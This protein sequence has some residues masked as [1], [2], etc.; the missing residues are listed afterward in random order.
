[1]KKLIA[2]LMVLCLSVSM[3]AGCG[4]K[5]G[6]EKD[7]K[8]KVVKGDMFDMLEAMG[9][10]TSGTVKADF[11]LSF[12]GK[13]TK[14]TLS[15]S[16]DAASKSCAF[17][18]SFSSDTTGT[19]MDVAVDTIAVIVD[20]NLYLNLKDLAGQ[21]MKLA[22]A[23]N[24]ASA[25]AFQDAVDTS[26]LG[27]FKFPLPDDLPN[28]NDK[29]QKNYV[30]SFVSL[31]ENMLKNTKM[32][33]KD[34]DYT[35]VLTTKEDYAQVA[36]AIRDFI[37]S[38]L[39]GL[40]DTTKGSMSDLNFDLEKYF[41]KLVETYKKD[42]VE[43]GKDY[44]LTEE[45]I[46]QMVKSV[47]DMKLNDQFANYKKQFEEQMSK[48]V[49]SDEDINA[50]A[51]NIDKTIEKIQKF[52]GDVPLKTTI[53]VSADDSYT[54][55][56]KF[57]S[58]AEGEEGAMSLTINVKP[59]DPGVKAPDDVMTV[60]QIADIATP[61]LGT[62]KPQPN[63]P[64]PTV[65]PVNT[66]TPEATPTEAPAATPT[67]EATPT[68]APAATPT[69]AQTEG[70]TSFQNGK[71]TIALGKGKTL[72]CDVAGDWEMSGNPEENSLTLMKGF[73]DILQFTTADVG[74]YSQDMIE[75]QLSAYTKL[76]EHGDWGVYTLVDGI[77]SCYT[78]KDGIMVVVTVFGDFD[79][80]KSQLDLISN[81]KVQ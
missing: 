63:Q 77:C 28:Y 6:D 27:W 44:G 36:T 35:A 26:K 43:I 66:P 76:G 75:S 55:D 9:N 22:A 10:T 5:G 4:S 32:E 73:T 19:K 38:D 41:D 59:G 69:P 80:A 33:G 11:S 71:A 72:T 13:S 12:G 65:E 23:S 68:E 52:E 14:G 64:T 29:L 57:E 30:N 51:A 58:S 81:L 62:V 42:A 49:L 70:T 21:L 1:M 25:K 37:K 67:P 18:L 15:Y 31:F 17:G 48:Q 74:N 2:L 3:L 40:M 47:K 34:G 53:K 7:P 46:D 20:N 16:V 45:Y 54:A 39:K 50:M 24:D 61:L 8:S 60:K 56:L 78:I 79:T